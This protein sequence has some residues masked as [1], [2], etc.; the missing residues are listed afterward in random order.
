[1]HL[2]LTSIA[3]GRHVYAVTHSTGTGTLE[4]EKHCF[5]VHALHCNTC[6]RLACQANIAG[7]KHSVC[8]TCL[9]TRN[10]GYACSHLNSMRS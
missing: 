6:I 1:M 7:F 2:N 5:I 8:V 3:L 4:A 9:G 10:S